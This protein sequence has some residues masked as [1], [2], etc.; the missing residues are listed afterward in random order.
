MSN[1][2]LIRFVCLAVFL[3]RSF[4][5]CLL[6]LFIY[7]VLPYKAKKVAHTRLPSVGFRS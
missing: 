6:Y 2:A 3:V 7:F 1:V 4:N 5:F